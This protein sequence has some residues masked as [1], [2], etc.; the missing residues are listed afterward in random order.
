M[1]RTLNSAGRAA[2]KAAAASER[3]NELIRK[4]HAEGS[5]MREIARA[6]GLSHSRIHQIIHG[7]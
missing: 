3:R 5:T 1:T 2:V 6:T 4:A 7:R